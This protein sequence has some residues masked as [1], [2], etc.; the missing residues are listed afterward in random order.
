MFDSDKWQEIFSTI[1]KNKLRT[2]LTLLGIACGMFMLIILL[3][4]GNSFRNGVM[5][6]FN[7]VTNSG[8]VWGRR[9]TISHNGF[10][11]GKSVQFDNSDTRMMLS[12]VREMK[13]LAPR[14]SL[15]QALTIHKDK[16][17]SFQVYGD[18]PDYNKIQVKNI[19][20]G[21]FINKKD[22]ENSRKV[23]VIGVGVQKILFDEEDDPIG[24][25]IT[26]NKINFRIIG[27]IKP[28]T[29]GGDPED[30]SDIHVPFS[31]FQKAFHYGDRVGWYGYAL[32]EN[33]D[34]EVTEA[35]IIKLLKEKNNIHPLDDDAVGNENVQQEFEEMTGLFDG[36]M[37]FTWFVGIST[38][39]AGIIG[40]SNIMLIIVKERTKEIGI[41]KSLGATP[42]SIVSLILQE[43]VFLTLV[44]GYIALI[45]GLGLLELIG[46]IM[47]KDGSL[48]F[49]APTVNAM[50][51]IGAL[52]IL[53]IGGALAGIMPARKAA[54]VSPI[55][56]IRVDG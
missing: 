53:V 50:V 41:R 5:A 43:S 15:G 17:G 48:P 29:G 21:R 28:N 54:S 27:I 51:P 18:Y 8:F 13:Y 42:R 34:M 46:L 10:Q 49:A 37:Y 3:G 33:E 20:I 56:A 47:P 26:I 35:K 1:R 45:G 12:R 14:N 39:L 30:E 40:I 6:D 19:P 52:G 11:P 36:L 32:H 22:I 16:N 24:K 23:A 55:E 2:F 44:G 4:G 9:T 31:T 25:F 7:F 38:L